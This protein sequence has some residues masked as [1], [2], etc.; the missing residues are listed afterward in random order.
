MVNPRNAIEEIRSEL[1]RLRADVGAVGERDA[2]R[3]VDR[4]GGFATLKGS[5]RRP[6]FQVDDK[7]EVILQELRKLPD[8]AG[9]ERIRS[10]FDT[11]SERGKVPS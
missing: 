3:I 11:W 7:A 5:S 8:D 4:G 9:P 2:L 10:E 6:Y 1:F